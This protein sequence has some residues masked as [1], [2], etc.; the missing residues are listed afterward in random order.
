MLPLAGDDGERLPN[1][2]IP[3]PSGIAT[4]IRIPNTIRIRDRDR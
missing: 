3:I 4:I 1:I 2:V